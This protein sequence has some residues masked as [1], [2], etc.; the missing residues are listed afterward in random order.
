[1]LRRLRAP[2]AIFVAC[3]AVYGAMLGDRALRPSEDNHFVHL[4]RSYMQ[5]Q[6]GVVDNVPPGTNDWACYDTLDHGPCPPGRYRFAAADAERYR[7]YV[8]F[9][10]LPAVVILPVVAVMDLDT[11]D[12]LVWAILAGL[13]PA[14]LYVLLRA[15][16]ESGRST[17]T[18]RENVALSL[19]F[20][21]GTVF[22]FT[23][24]QG[25][26]WFAAHVVAVPLI[27]LY[28]MLSLDARRPL[29]AGLVL[30]LA[31]MTRPSTLYLAPFFLIEALRVARAADAPL[32]P[33]DGSPLGKV[34]IF[35]RGIAWSAVVRRLAIFGAPVVAVGL[36][37]M[38]MNDARFE[39]PLEFGHE[40]LSIRWSGR[41]EKWG[42]F[43]FHYFAKNLAVFTSA[44]PWLSAEAPYVKVSRHGLAL[45]ITTPALLW[46]LW[47]KKVDTTM[48]GLYAAAAVV[49]VLNLCYQNSGW[50]QFGYRFALDYMPVLF[51]LVALG[52]RRF[53]LGFWALA[54][55]ALGVNAFGA[56]TF[57][58][59]PEFYDGD[60]TQNVIF[61]P[62]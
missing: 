26:V 62:D 53:G 56:A 2:A 6:L 28:V 38:W 42:L 60:P 4:A 27:V 41:I 23:A 37:A 32:V 61:Q 25:T 29:L 14:L 9:P 21:F 52:A 16:G 11:P 59:A 47:P 54:L 33:P 3:A 13:G 15:L 17:R 12:R 20:A 39:D 1:V 7:W 24:V 55:F 40:F 31:F 35:L 50:I 49:C 8:S 48:V 19:L 30:G 43:N 44:F 45:W 34:T 18:A 5:G 51:V 58:R 57:D 22:F 36:V 46:T 10:P